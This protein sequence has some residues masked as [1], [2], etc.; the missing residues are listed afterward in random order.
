MTNG[1]GRQG[2]TSLKRAI[3]VGR[4]DDDDNDGRRAGGGKRTAAMEG[5]EIC[6]R[7]KW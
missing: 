5:G 7:S 6:G 1:V 3:A 4:Q 2:T